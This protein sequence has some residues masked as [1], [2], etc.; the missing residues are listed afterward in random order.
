MDG[1]SAFFPF[2][3]MRVYSLKIAWE[4]MDGPTAH[5]TG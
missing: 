4:F 3:L 5:E 2:D 1:C